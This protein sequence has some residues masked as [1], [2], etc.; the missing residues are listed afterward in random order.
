LP[1]LSLIIAVYNK[2]EVLRLVLAACSRQTLRDFEIIV[3]DDGSG[4]E[5]ADVIA[6]ARRLFRL[7][8]SHQWQ[9]DIG[10]RKNEILNKAVRSATSEYL[11]FTDGD[12]LPEKNFLFDHRREREPGRVL[13]GRR[14]EM[15]ERWSNSL[16]LDNILS[17]RFEQ[18]GLSELIDGIKGQALRLEDRIRITSTFLRRI[19]SQR[20]KGILGSNFSVHR[21]DIVAINGFDEEYDGPG[22]GEDS[23][24]QYRLS[25]IGVKG[26]S[27]RNLAIQFHVYHPRTAPF[28]T[29]LRRFEEV[30]RAG[31]PRCKYGLEKL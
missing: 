4:D 8:I 11:V 12:C 29:T 24:I 22:H 21:A 15:S 9:E 31:I 13:L 5:V 30:R 25:L 10:W 3:A 16:T 20:A 18:I 1:D 2:P 28:E 27:L 7:P 26:K 19:S 17:G 14:V 6:D 23:D